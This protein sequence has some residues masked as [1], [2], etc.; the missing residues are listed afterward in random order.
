[1]KNVRGEEITKKVNENVM[2]MN[3]N[4]S[5]FRCDSMREVFHDV[6]NRQQVSQWQR[7]HAHLLPY[8]MYHLF[9]LSSD[10]KNQNGGMSHI[11]HRTLT[12]T[13]TMA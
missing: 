12:K 4:I 9:S 1:M 3:T 2:V 10:M 11:V 13:R 6:R 5:L 8:I 7:D